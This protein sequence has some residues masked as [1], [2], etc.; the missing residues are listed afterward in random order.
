MGIADAAEIERAIA[1]FA[2]N[3]N[4]GLIVTVVRSHSCIVN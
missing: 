2:R 1:T 4:S 3:P